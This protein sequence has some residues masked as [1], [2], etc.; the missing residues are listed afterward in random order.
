MLN[1]GAAGVVFPLLF[2]NAICTAPLLVKN[3]TG[4]P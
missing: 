1:G 4:R 2:P 3:S